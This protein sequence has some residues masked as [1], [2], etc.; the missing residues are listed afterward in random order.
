MK[1]MTKELGS[2]TIKK[3]TDDIDENNLED[4][5]SSENQISFKYN[6]AFFTL[7]EKKNLNSIFQPISYTLHLLNPTTK[8]PMISVYPFLDSADSNSFGVSDD[9]TQRQLSTLWKKLL[10]GDKEAIQLL[11]N[12]FK[13]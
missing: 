12:F 3:L 9:S 6:D 4:I 10:S 1:R 8:Q 7:S 13:D 2:K 5:K 11:G